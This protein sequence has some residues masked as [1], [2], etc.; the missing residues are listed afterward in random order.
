[1]AFIK[2]INEIWKKL[3]HHPWDWIAHTLLGLIAFF[4]NDLLLKGFDKLSIGATI[5]AA[6]NVIV[7]VELVQMDVFGMS[8]R[9]AGDTVLDLMAGGLGI[10]LAVL[11]MQ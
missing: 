5:L 4:I 6:I 1:M 10:Y 3:N 7:V 2:K 9:R 11:L 8:W